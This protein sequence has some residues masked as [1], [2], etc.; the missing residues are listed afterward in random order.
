MKNI[1]AKISVMAICA[2]LIVM[3]CGIVPAFAADAVEESEEVTAE[4]APVDVSDESDSELEPEPAPAEE[5]EEESADESVSEA[6]ISDSEEEILSD[7]ESAESKPE[8]AVCEP[9]AES[10]ASDDASDDSKSTV[11]KS[12]YP[13]ISQRVMAGEGYAD[14]SDLG[15]S[16]DQ[17]G[18]LSA[19]LGAYADSVSFAT[20]EGC[21][22]YVFF[23]D[24]D[25]EENAEAEAEAETEAEA[26]ESEEH[27]AI[28]IADE[29]DRIMSRLSETVCKRLTD[30]NGYADISD[31]GVT[32]NQIDLLSAW[33]SSTS[34]YDYVSFF[35]DGGHVMY[36]TVEDS[37]DYCDDCF[38]DE[39]LET[40][41][42]RL[43]GSDTIYADAEDPVVYAEWT[44]EDSDDSEDAEEITDSDDENAETD[45]ELPLDEN[46]QSPEEPVGAVMGFALCIAAVLRHLSG[47]L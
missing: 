12:L 6:E 16:A 38:E 28:E 17:S 41:A 34:I 30:G 3:Y 36:V 9:E 43:T 1:I 35:S 23:N 46:E 7:E 10:E 5:A 19:Y 11:D 24:I 2:A 25:E 39:S 21:I 40:A 14:I 44:D 42:P 45:E 26:E 31:L 4:M 33:L 18:S 47:C 29:G 20:N 13:E 8:E 37:A 22:T 32:E 27:E 15:I